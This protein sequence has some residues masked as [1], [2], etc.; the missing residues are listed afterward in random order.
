MNL[1]APSEIDPAFIRRRMALDRA[2]CASERKTILDVPL[3]ADWPFAPRKACPKG[4][5]DEHA[6]GFPPVNHDGVPHVP[7][8]CARCDNGWLER[9]N[10]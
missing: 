3:V 10:P 9:L 1:Y 8:R 2:G 6:A 4:H 7:R 5:W